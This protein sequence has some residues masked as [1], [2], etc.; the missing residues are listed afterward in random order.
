MKKRIICLWLLCA[1][2]VSVYASG[3]ESTEISPNPVGRGDLFTLTIIVD[4]DSS[5]DVDLPL[6]EL[7]EQLTL[8]RGPYIRSF[9][10]TAANGERSRKVRIT[11]TFKAQRS[12]RMIFPELSV[13]VDGGLYKTEPM[14]LRVGLYKNRKLYMPLEVGWYPAFEDIYAG[15]AVPVFLMVSNQEVVTLFD[16]VRVATPRDGFFEKAEGLG[17]INQKSIGGIVLYDIPAA[18]YIY[19]SPVAGNVRIPAAGVDNEGITGW[20]DNLDLKIKAVPEKI[21][22]TGA[23]GT[24]SYQAEINSRDVAYGDEV[25]LTAVVSGSGNLNY[26]KVPEPEISGVLLVSREETADY[27]RSMSGYTGSKSVVWTYSPADESAAEIKMPEFSFLNKELGIIETFP[28]RTYRLAVTAAPPAEESIE[29]EKLI[30]T[31][32][33]PDRDAGLEWKNYYKD[34]FNYIWLLPA[35]IFYLLFRILKGRRTLVALIITVI[36]MVAAVSLVT[37]FYPA[38]ETDISKSAAAYY[39]NAVQMYEEGNLTEAVHN[40]RTAVYLEPMIRQYRDMLSAVEKKHGFI[41]PVSPSIGLHP[42]LFFYITAAALNLFFIVAFL[43]S[44]KPG[45]AV[46][47]LFI[48]FALAALISAGCMGYSHI[49]RGELTGIIT[50]EQTFIKKIPR[51]SAENWLMMKPG[52]SV[53]IIDESGEFLLIETGMGV[54]G[55]IQKPQIVSDR[56][57]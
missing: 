4:H 2:A 39:N 19:T 29:D 44:V 38:E 9:I 27:N 45:G 22:A 50:G 1:L 52:T 54:K 42:D 11:A 30:F 56:I 20:T 24:F 55:W 46:S 34:P 57:Q 47:V 26:L 13:I 21:S 53:R 36:V 32:V 3:I 31:A 43:K 28:E 8:W 48:M 10:Q 40:L 25:V 6:K 23:I 17:D 33:D 14:L 35:G 41:T 16:R 49:E 18:S 51:D 37:A 12:G 15:E 7:P 5:A